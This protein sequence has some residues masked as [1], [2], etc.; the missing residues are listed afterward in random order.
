MNNRSI[1]LRRGQ[2]RRPTARFAFVAVLDEG[3]HE[4]A[5]HDINHQ[6][7]SAGAETATDLPAPY[8]AWP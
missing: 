1:A 3:G 8:Y 6:E 7:P 5:Q 2:R 4:L